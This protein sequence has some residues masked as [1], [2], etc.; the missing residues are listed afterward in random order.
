MSTYIHLR[1]TWEFLK[2]N[3]DVKC[4]SHQDRP[5]CLAGPNVS[6]MHE[7]SSIEQGPE[8]EARKVVA[9]QGRTL[10]C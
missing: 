5:R 2:D 9:L 3:H 6:M 7:H 10:A 1:R 4:R 8:E